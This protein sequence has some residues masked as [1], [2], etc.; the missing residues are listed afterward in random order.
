VLTEDDYFD[1]LINTAGKRRQI[2]PEV[3]RRLTKS[4]LLFL[5]FRLEEWDFRVL[6]RTI[7]ALEGSDLLQNYSQVAV[8]LDPEDGQFLEPDSARRYLEKHTRFA[9]KS[10]CIYWGKVEQF[11]D[12]LGRE[13]EAWK[14]QNV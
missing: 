10:I 11:L 14:K 2:P 12:E 7:N 5:G 6:V 9:G 1:F 8:Q 13:W 4:S 3:R